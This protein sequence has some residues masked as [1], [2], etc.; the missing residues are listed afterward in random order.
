MLD[1]RPEKTGSIRRHRRGARCTESGAQPP[2][3]QRGRRTQS[4]ISS[5]QQLTSA[6]RPLSSQEW[7]K[8]EEEWVDQTRR[9]EVTTLSQQ[10]REERDEAHSRRACD[11]RMTTKT[12]AKDRKTF[13]ILSKSFRRLSTSLCEADK[14]YWKR[15]EA[16]GRRSAECSAF[17]EG[18]AREALRP[19]A[20]RTRNLEQPQKDYIVK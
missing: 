7:L 16:D 8:D 12:E 1:E 19:D 4:T 10:R 2:R 14:R 13:Y 3:R 5:K 17:E 20:G 9:T 15:Q 11:Q 6:V 18:G